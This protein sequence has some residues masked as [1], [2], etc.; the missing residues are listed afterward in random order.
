MVELPGLQWLGWLDALGYIDVTVMK[1]KC[2]KYGC[3]ADVALMIAGHPSMDNG[4]F[5]VS[6]GTGRVIGKGCANVALQ[7]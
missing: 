4:P 1:N 6:M 2:H 7:G 3:H 5:G